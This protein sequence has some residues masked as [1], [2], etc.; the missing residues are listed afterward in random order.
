MRFLPIASAL[1]VVVASFALRT[2]DGAPPPGATVVAL[3]GPKSA[4]GRLLAIDATNKRVD[5][6]VGQV[7]KERQEVMID[8]YR[9]YTDDQLRDR[10]KGGVTLEMLLAIVNTDALPKDVRQRAAETIYLPR[11]LL[12]DQTLDMNGRKEKRKRAEFSVKVNKLLQDNDE[13]VRQLG[14]TI[15]DGLWTGWRTRKPALKAFDPRN[16]SSGIE[17]QKAWAEVFRS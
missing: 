14:N 13:F 8:V 5:W 11:V 9:A 15:L 2:A 7:K 10:P 16:R 12:H 1:L 6:L 4:A 3:P 17:A